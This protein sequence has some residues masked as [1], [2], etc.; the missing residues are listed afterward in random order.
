MIFDWS[1]TLVNDL[2][3]VWEATNA[4]FRRAGAPELTLDEFR[5]E[6][7]LPFV[8]FYKRR[9]SHVDM[10]QL[11]E[12][13]HDA[14]RRVQAKIRPIPRARE[15]V[16][17][18]RRRGAKTLL[19]SSAH[20]AHFEDQARAAGFEGLLDH[21]YVGVRDKRDRIGRIL[22]EHN[23]KPSETMFVGDMEHDIETA[24]AGGVCACAVLTGYNHTD[25]LVAARPDLIVEHLGELQQLLDQADMD[26]ERARALHQSKRASGMGAGSRPDPSDPV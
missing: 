19:L 7:C 5:R 18:C 2:P 8:R 9:L 10:A 26:F 17:F 15:F 4:V 3:A 24:R 16:E 22:K 25:Q 14:F 21:C 12:W 20:P 13:F 11:E 6:F 23:A 1:G